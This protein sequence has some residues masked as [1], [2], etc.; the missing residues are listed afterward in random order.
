MIKLT[1]AMKKFLQDY[2][3]EMGD[4]AKEHR[5]GSTFYISVDCM[6]TKEVFE[7]A[8]DSGIILPQELDGLIVVLH[9][10][11]SD[12]DGTDV[13]SFGLYQHL[14]TMNPKYVELMTEAQESKL[15][16]DFIYKHCPEYITK[17][18]TV[19]FEVA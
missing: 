10:T 17:L 2:A 6:I 14:Q 8:A 12:D 15:L 16:Q 19:E 18:E 3:L 9:G 4:S 5:R 13:G 1:K 7:D 11:W